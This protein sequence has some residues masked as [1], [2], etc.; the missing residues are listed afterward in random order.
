MA[1][2]GGTFFI[3][4]TPTVEGYSHTF[5]MAFVLTSIG[6]AM[7][8]VIREPEP[9]TVRAP[10]ALGSRLKQIPGLLREDPAFA[11][12]VGA[13]ASPPWGAWR[14]PSTSCLQGP[15]SG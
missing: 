9:P 14:P 15:A 13:G 6:L 5:I 11:R 8:V 1:W 4:E 3:G 2:L 12:Y 7:L 10:T